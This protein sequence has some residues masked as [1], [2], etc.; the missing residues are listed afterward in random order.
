MF[1]VDIV[2][3]AILV[4]AAFLG[5]KKGLVNTIFS[6]VAFLVSIILSFILYTPVSSFINNNTQLNQKIETIV[7]EKLQTEE[8]DNNIYNNNVIKNMENSAKDVA[9]K[10]TSKQVA[11]LGVNLISIICVYLV[12]RIVLIL[13]KGVINGIA[14]LPV[15][16]QFNEIGG[17][18]AGFAKGLVL[19]YLVFA[20]VILLSDM[21]DFSGFVSLI[22]KSLLGKVFFDNNV[23]I[24]ILK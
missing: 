7:T 15:I 10:E 19:I 12:A 11:M 16:K 1:I 20:I 9:I 22:D 8:N 17:L 21:F 14:S 3:I 2:L 18:V 24:N 4:L 23:I 5:Y 6:V 13:L